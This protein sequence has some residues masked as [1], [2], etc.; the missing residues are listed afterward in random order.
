M[1][2]FPV[3]IFR[4][5]TFA[6]RIA[7]RIKRKMAGSALVLT[8]ALGALA[9]NA[10][11]SSAPVMP[12]RGDSVP[13]DYS[14]PD[15]AEAY[16]PQPSAAAHDAALSFVRKTGISKNLSLL[17]LHDVKNSAAVRAAIRQ[18]GMDK[19]QETVVQVIRGVQQSYN[20]DWNQ[21][22]AG[23]YESHF[24]ARALQSLMQQRDASPHFIRLLGLQEEIASAVKAKGDSIFDKARADVMS[25][26]KAALPA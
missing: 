23:V 8:V 14:L 12:S 10:S 24:D 18:Y 7:S 16:I 6:I 3:D 20:A 11:A 22:L 19:V 15:F 9:P 5:M 17:L 21:M 13:A 4:L 25:G 2:S 26:I 1:L